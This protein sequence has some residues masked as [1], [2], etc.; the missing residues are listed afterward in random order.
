MSNETHPL[1]DGFPQYLRHSEEDTPVP[2]WK[3]ITRSTQSR[4]EEIIGHVSRMIAGTND[5]Q[6]AREHWEHYPPGTKRSLALLV[7]KIYDEGW[8]GAVG[9]IK[10]AWDGGFFFWPHSTERG[11]LRD[12]LVS[13]SGK[14]GTY[15][16]CSLR[17]GLFAY[18]NAWNHKA[19]RQ[20]WME[21]DAG[22]AALHVGIFE[23]GSAEVHMDVFN[24]LFIKGAPP[25]DLVR[26]PMVGTYNHRQFLLHRRW[27]QSQYAQ[28][29]RTSANFYHLMRGQVPLSF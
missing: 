27:E 25:E 4:N 14:H 3:Q 6:A 28:V 11:S 20:A 13:K 24:P 29:T 1:P 9:Q 22:S 12:L 19:W 16:F 10:G 7:D 21:T 5:E 23:D 26:I 8:L 2:S 18:L 15:I 17:N